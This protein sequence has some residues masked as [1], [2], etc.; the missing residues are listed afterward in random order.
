MN[1]SDTFIGTENTTV[2][3]TNNSLPSW[4]FYSSETIP[5]IKKPKTNMGDKE[6]DVCHGEK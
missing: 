4:S 1:V 5:A 3:K 2:N 6:S